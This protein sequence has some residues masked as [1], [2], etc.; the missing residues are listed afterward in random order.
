VIVP[1]WCEQ[2]FAHGTEFSGIEHRDGQ[3]VTLSAQLAFAGNHQIRHHDEP[4]MQNVAS[5]KI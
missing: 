4:P 3:S 5:N 2:N 1:R